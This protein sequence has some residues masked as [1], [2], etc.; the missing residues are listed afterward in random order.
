VT[1]TDPFE[2]VF[3]IAQ[4][5]TD[6]RT[7]YRN[8]APG[9]G[10]SAAYHWGLPTIA[11][12]QFADLPHSAGKTSSVRCSA[13]LCRFYARQLLLALIR[14]GIETMGDFL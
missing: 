2:L 6:T 12:G 4:I 10:R 3:A 14:Q 7:G 13:W 5:A 9:F 8:G 11:P 1:T